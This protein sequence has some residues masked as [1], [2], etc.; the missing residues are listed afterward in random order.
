MG[1]GQA[2]FLTLLF[3]FGG[4]FIYLWLAHFGNTPQV[5]TD[6]VQELTST[7]GSNKSAERDMVYLL[8]AL[9]SLSAIVFF[10]F[11]NRTHRTETAADGTR[12]MGLIGLLLLI[13]G[14]TAYAV[15]GE[16]SPVLTAMTGFWIL[17]TVSG[18]AYA[19]SA[20]SCFIAG[21][22]ALCGLYRLY[23]YLGGGWDIGEESLTLL[24][25]FAS[26][27]LL[28]MSRSKKKDFFLLVFP[29]LQLAIPFTFL[30]FLAAGY[31]VAGVETPV[32][33]TKRII[34]PV[35]LLIIVCLIFAVKKLAKSRK[36]GC[37]MDELVSF[38]TLLAILNFNSYSG[39]G[40]IVPADMH[41]P[42]EN[43]I[44]FSQIFELGQRPFSEYIPVSGMYSV[45][46]GAFLALF[47]KGEYAAYNVTENLF[48]L[49][50]AA[51][52][53]LAARKQIREGNLLLLALLIPI[54]RYNRIA[55][56]LPFMLLL[57]HPALIRRRSLWLKAWFL[58]SLVHGL[59]YPLFGAAVCLA[60]LPLAVLQFLRWRKG[61][62]SRD[63]K[64]PLFWLGWAGCL[65][66]AI[67]SIPLLLGTLKH[68]LAMSAQ[69]IF[70][71]GLARFG[72]GMPD[73]FLS[74]VP[75]D[76]L[77]LLL[78]MLFSFLIPVSVVWVSVILAMKL[79]QIRVEGRKLLIGNAEAAAVC[80]SVGIAMFVSFS[81]T[82]VRLDVFDIY[83]RS[84]GVIFAAAVMFL[85]IAARYC[86]SGT[87]RYVVSG[88][89]VFLLAAVMGESA[90]GIAED[91]KLAAAYTVP[92]DRIAADSSACPRLGSCF[93]KEEDY[94]KLL[95][96]YNGGVGLDPAESYLGLGDFGYFYLYNIR[97]ASVMEMMTIRGYGAAQETVELLRR[98]GPRVSALDSFSYYY[99]Y[100]W[101][102]ASGEYAWDAE[103]AKFLPHGGDPEEARE[104]NK[105]AGIA[106]EERELGLT[107]SSWGLS[108]ESLNGIFT[109]AQ[110]AYSL[111]QGADGAEILFGESLDGDDADFL[112]LAL[113]DIGETY[114]YILVDHLFDA[115]QEDVTPFAARLMRKNRNPGR[116]ITLSWQDDAGEEHCMHCDLGQGRLLIPLGS[117][118]GWL[119]NSHAQIRI[120]AE[121]SGE[122]AAMPA[123]GE[124]RLLKLRE[125]E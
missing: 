40:L 59:Y 41:H 123:I 72:Q 71:D 39:R 51:L 28:L 23:V 74:Y 82:L 36:G 106:A 98:N 22:Y 26:C 77:R 118:A 35:W 58:T 55:L 124:L 114:D 2:L 33:L 68:M 91:E 116:T 80:I 66:P 27:I 46:Q 47:G 64:K 53:L 52:L 90:R 44:A 54:L 8:S 65:L 108:M 50:I 92:E 62:L 117:G 111:G 38:G 24:A 89:A 6:V 29:Y 122:A 15:Y 9:G 115:V 93:M 61:E 121:D 17:L 31:R 103:T 99:L 73:N 10:L 87:M 57:V 19:T 107:P 21:L 94:T 48:Y 25:F 100:H 43:I 102:L 76:G 60:F 101:L 88:F 85:L 12:S 45:V 104:R 79:G 16:C 125:V 81:Y 96:R 49:A 56:I 110:A 83:A 75:S 112:Y 32:P 30:I 97:G 109:E 34:L 84:A 78:Y 14:G 37:G 67:L 119:L 63:V 42:F 13:S 5:F 7:E 70:A 1:N 11:H 113:D 95:A 86:G 4:L 105:A 120:T 3:L 69:T 20:L 18:T